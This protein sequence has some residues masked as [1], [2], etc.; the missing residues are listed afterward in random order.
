MEKK[1]DGSYTRMLQAILNKS[2]RQHPTKQQLYGHLPPIT[3]TIQVRQTRHEGHCWK[4]KDEL[5]SNVILWTP[6][7]G[8]AKVGLPART[9]IQQLCADTGYGLEDLLGTMDDRDRW[10][11]RVR[12]ICAGSV[13][14]WWI[15]Y[16]WFGNQSRRR[17]FWIQISF[18]LL[19]SSSV[20]TYKHTKILH[21]CLENLTMKKKKQTILL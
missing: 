20:N 11:E 7:H 16:P 21:E 6:S 12:E 19:K 1:L 5:I 15:L 13:T 9:Y 17:K 8:R 2:G 14:W 10:R 3:K 4:S 18:T